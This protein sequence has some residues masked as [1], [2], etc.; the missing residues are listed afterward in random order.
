MSEENQNEQNLNEDTPN[1]NVEKEH[2]SKNGGKRAAWMTVGALIIVFVILMGVLYKTGHLCGTTNIFRGAGDDANV[3]AC[4]NGERVTHGEFEASLTP[5][6][7]QKL[8]TLRAATGTQA[9]AQIAK[10][11]SAALKNQINVVILT[12]KAEG[13]GVTVTDKELDERMTAMKS[14]FAEISARLPKENQVTFEEQIKQSGRTVDS[15]RAFVRK[16]MLITQYLMQKVG[17]KDIPVSDEAVQ[18][19]YDRYAANPNLSEEDKMTFE[20]AKPMIENT[21]RQQKAAKKIQQYIKE[22]RNDAD[23]IVLL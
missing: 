14:Q 20:E 19:L 18:E 22:V 7:E 10:I 6:V 15:L 11:Q 4:V 5:P 3:V 23:V 12:Q 13:A 8:E 9:V 2:R 1:D 16:Q 17:G 21:L